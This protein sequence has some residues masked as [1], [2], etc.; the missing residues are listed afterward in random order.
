M[1]TIETS[2]SGPTAANIADVATVPIQ[3]RSVAMSIVAALALV[4]LLR[5]GRQ[6]FVPLAL[7]ILV[8]FALNPFVSLLERVRVP[9]MIGSAFVV[10]VAVALLASGSY[11]LR[12]QAEDVIDGLPE[13][14]ANIREQVNDWQ[15]GKASPGALEKLKEAAKEIERTTAEAT[16]Q[17]VTHGVTKV[18]IAQNPFRLV[19]YLWSGSRGLAGFVSDAVMVTFLVFF[20]LSSGDLFKRKLVRIIGSRLSDKRETVEALNE[21][22]HQVERFLFIQ[23]M[24]SIG[25]AVCMSTALWSFGIR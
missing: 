13:A 6:L 19:D 2:N 4:V 10:L 8:A 9:R 20:L 16:D 18:Q 14:I 3:T 11:A 23:I 1:S 22:T 7:A 5:Y 25:V 17:P 24:T 12:S 21:I 15:A